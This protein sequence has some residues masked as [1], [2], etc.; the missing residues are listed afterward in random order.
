MHVYDICHSSRSFVPANNYY[1]QPTFALP[2]PRKTVFC[3]GPSKR[4]AVHVP[5]WLVYDLS[6]DKNND[7]F[8]SLVMDG[9]DDDDD[10]EYVAGG[11]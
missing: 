2:V 5:T 8:L 7:A 6:L 1:E 3:F 10:D 4:N 9:N 11:R